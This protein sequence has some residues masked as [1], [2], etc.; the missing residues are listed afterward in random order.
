V[1]RA[2]LGFY[3]IEQGTVNADTGYV[4]TANA[5]GTIGTTALPFSQFSGAGTF[6]AGNGLTLTGSVFS[7]TSPVAVAD[8][9]TGLTSLGSGIAT[10]LGTP[11]SANL[12]AAVSDETGSG[13]L[14]FATSSNAYHADAGRGYRNLD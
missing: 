12:A 1:G 9:G 6:T 5:G 14:V 7:L 4:C 8:G 2:D 3:F 10:F 11:S 13:A